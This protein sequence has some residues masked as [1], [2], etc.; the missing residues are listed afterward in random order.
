MS[1]NASKVRVVDDLLDKEGAINLPSHSVPTVLIYLHLN[2]TAQPK[3]VKI[4]GPPKK[5]PMTSNNS[6]CCIHFGVE[7]L[8]Y[9]VA[10]ILLD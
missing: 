2:Y 5:N 9:V 1:Q 6:Q 3:I 4:M 8:S 10:N 7:S